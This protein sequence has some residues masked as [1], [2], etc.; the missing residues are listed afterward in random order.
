M[1]KRVSSKWVGY[2]EEGLVGLGQ[3][4]MRDFPNGGLGKG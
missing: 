4:S 1:P 3:M 2:G